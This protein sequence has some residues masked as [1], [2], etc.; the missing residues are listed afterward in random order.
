MTALVRHIVN[1]TAG[2]AGLCLLGLMLITFVDVVGRYFF[3]AALPFAVEIIQL[4][5]G[6]L[7]FLGLGLTTLDRGHISVDLITSSVPGFVQKVL[8]LTSAIAASVFFSLAAWQLSVRAVTFKSDKLTTEVLLLPV[9]PV[10]FIMAIS[11]AFVA[12][13]CIFQIFRADKAAEANPFAEFDFSES[14]A[15]TARRS[16]PR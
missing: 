12:M 1:W 11:A 6:L 15:S 2:A 10:A 8:A 5:M 3:D 13:I 4:G 7:V 16:E 9:Y 14:G